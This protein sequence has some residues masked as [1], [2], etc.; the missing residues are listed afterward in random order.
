SSN[1][2]NQTATNQVASVESLN[3][4]AL[5]LN[6]NSDNLVSEVQKFTV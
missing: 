2:V 3:Q 6:A 5:M 1:N 4:S